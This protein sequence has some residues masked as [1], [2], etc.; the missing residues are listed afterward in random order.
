MRE[1]YQVYSGNFLW[2]SS[3]AFRVGCLTKR[4]VDWRDSARF[5]GIFLASGFSCS[6]ALSQPAR[7]PLTQ[8]VGWLRAKQ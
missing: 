3:L 6:Q 8:T 5:T 7:Q 2:Q 1:S 4:A